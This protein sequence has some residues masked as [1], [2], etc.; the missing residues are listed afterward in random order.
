MVALRDHLVDK[1]VEIPEWFGIAESKK[2]GFMSN[3]PVQPYVVLGIITAQ[4]VISIWGELING[5]Q[6]K[7]IIYSDW[8]QPG[9]FQEDVSQEGFDRPGTKYDTLKPI[10][11]KLFSGGVSY[12][13]LIKVFVHVDDGYVQPVPCAYT[14]NHYSDGE[15]FSNIKAFYFVNGALDF[16]VTVNF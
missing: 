1:N 7:A 2:R 4:P 13:I 11:P 14:E 15:N 10:N 8:G 3:Q 5:Q 6:V 9:T 16:V 12:N